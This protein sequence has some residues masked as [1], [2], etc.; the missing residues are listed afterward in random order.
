VKTKDTINNIILSKNSE[1]PD[2][3]A[4][5]QILQ[6]Y[7]FFEIVRLNYLKGLKKR[8]ESLYKTQLLECSAFFSDRK[9]AWHFINDE[10]KGSLSDEMLVSPVFASDYFAFTNES[11][12]RETLR[13]LAAKLKSKRM[14][15][16]AEMQADENSQ[17][18]DFTEDS[19]KKLIE[20]K[21]YLQALT[22]LRQLNLHNSKK[23]IYFVPQI[24]FLETIVKNTR[25]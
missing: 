6:K 16:V 17:N 11:T 10:K 2:I 25:K 1:I 5:S 20:E 14:E 15:K 7:P 4:L 24:K 19:V 21:K 8:D 3:F 13:S 23:S 22:I 18:V 9:F 12:E